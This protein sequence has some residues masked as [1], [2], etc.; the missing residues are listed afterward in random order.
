MVNKIVLNDDIL[1]ILNS[2]KN[3]GYTALVVGGYIR[4]SLLGITPHDCDIATNCSYD[5]LLEIFKGYN[6]KEIG[7]SFGI[8]Q[9]KINNVEYEIAKFRTDGVYSDS[10]RPD[11]VEFVDNFY[12]DAKRRDFTI[13]AMGYDGAKL[14]DYFKGQEDLANGLIRFVGIGK[15]RINEDALRMLRAIRFSTKRSNLELYN[16]TF[17]NISVM[18]HGI[19]YISEERVRLELDKI[20]LSDYPSKG[21]RLLQQTGL[22]KYII[23]ELNECVGFNQNNSHH[24]KDLLEH[25]LTVVDHTKPILVN[26]LS[27]LLH[28]IGKVS[29]HSLDENGESHYYLHHKVSADMAGEILT[30]LKYDNKTIETVK[31]LIYDHMNKNSKQS[32]KVIKRFVIRVGVENLPN[33]F[34]LLQADI[35]GHKP[36]HN[37]KSLDNLKQK[38]YD[39]I[40]REEPIKTSQLVINGRDIMDL[41]IKEG[42]LIGELLEIC[43]N[44]VLDNPDYNNKDYLIKLI[45]DEI[46]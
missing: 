29:T 39:I 45:M 40:N 37:F 24:N 35:I 43:M 16:P 18:S 33:M 25:I 30:R 19:K 34:D 1:S 12:E 6:P 5:E 7:K 4:D 44:R 26:R 10:R 31:R 42:K 3:K 17:D 28:D 20:L 14:Y 38:C 27:A 9:I 32:D 15:E 21:I 8:I 22:L 11:T 46:N 2:I 41:G 13:N 23:P 36:P